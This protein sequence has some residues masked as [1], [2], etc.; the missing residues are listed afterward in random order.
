[1]GSEDVERGSS[2]RSM[3]AFTRAVLTDLYALERMIEED[4]FERGEITVNVGQQGR[5]HGSDSGSPDGSSL[6]VSA[7]ASSAAGSMGSRTVWMSLFQRPSSR[8]FRQWS[9]TSAKHVSRRRRQ[10]SRR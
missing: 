8:S 1:M 3:R 2:E 6:G 4:R 5:S 10:S 7:R 9:A